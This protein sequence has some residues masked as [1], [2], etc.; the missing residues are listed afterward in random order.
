M[1]SVGK[2]RVPR[3]NILR[4]TALVVGDKPLAPGRW[5]GRR[6]PVRTVDLLVRN[7]SGCAVPVRSGR[8]EC[9]AGQWKT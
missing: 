5:S 2:V 3:N 4:N 7:G 1:K 6:F 9:L 8:K